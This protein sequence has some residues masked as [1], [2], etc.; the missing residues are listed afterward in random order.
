MAFT[1]QLGK[2][3]REP[4][5]PFRIAQV[6]GAEL[7]APNA[8]GWNA[9]PVVTDPLTTLD[10]SPITDNH[11][12]IVALVSL[13]Y[14]TT[15]IKVT[16]DW[17]RDRDEQLLFHLEYSIPDPKSSGYAYWPWLYAYSYIARASWEIAENGAYH[18]RVSVGDTTQTVTF[19]VTGMGAAPPPSGGIFDDILQWILSA[20]STI[21]ST[22][23]DWI[24][25][26]L[27]FLADGIT[28]AF[29]T[30]TGWLA[31]V[32]GALQLG[33]DQITAAVNGV[34]TM[35]ADLTGGMWLS[36]TTA[37]AHGLVSFTDTITGLFDGLYSW[38]GS[39][40]GGLETRI[41]SA[42]LTTA[43]SLL[44]PLLALPGQVSAELTSW[45]DA[46]VN[47]V[48]SLAYYIGMSATNIM[49]AI[50]TSGQSLLSSLTTTINTALSTWWDSFLGKLFDFGSWAGGLLDAI[51]AWLTVDVPGH[52][53]RWTA[54]LDDFVRIFWGAITGP[55]LLYCATITPVLITGAMAALQ[56]VSSALVDLLEQSM[57]AITT[58][59][60]TIGPVTP[61]SA[62]SVHASLV[63]VMTTVVA[64]L[65][66]MTIAG[67][68]T[69]MGSKIGLGNVSAMIYDLT[70]YKALTG[71][72]VGALA[73]AAVAIP[74]RYYYNSL[75]RPNLPGVGQCA[76]ME[77]EGD[78]KP[79]EYTKLMGFH[80]FPDEWHENMKD[81]SYRAPTP[82]T[83]KIMAKDGTF[84]DAM[85]TKALQRGHY[86]PEFIP[87]MIDSIRKAS[88]G[89][90]Q[91]IMISAAVNRFKLGLTDQPTFE[92]EL[93]VLQCAENLLP[94]YVYGAN[95]DYTTSFTLELMTA[96]VDG[97]RAGNI[98]IED[99]R[100]LLLGLG[101]MP[102]RVEADVYREVVRVKPRATTTAVTPGAATYTT[103]AGKLAVDTIRRQRRKGVLDRTM[104]I[105]ALLKLGMDGAYAAAVADNDDIRLGESPATA[106]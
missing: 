66:A 31:G 68:M 30:L 104:Q 49:S 88:V 12:A 92:N 15:A 19:E 70:N 74:L 20:T 89:T 82:Y 38:L 63:K 46:V 95:L 58:A 102:E 40:L 50:S 23:N 34:Y 28:A 11:E 6:F 45:A 26:S 3:L 84:D 13:T 93:R 103:D 32:F 48:S 98:S 54:I 56:P 8:N 80:G 36:I 57:A 96:Y 2:G 35:L 97:V 51:G 17:Y 21:T 16:L 81:L 14:I 99:Y 71:A 24:T 1:V 39:E 59:T 73:A 69:V 106:A 62:L 60:A 86:R 79:G 22:V 72:F 83:M 85:M 61:G 47:A 37:V 9:V 100:D 4:V 42:V 101:L 43:A 41:V 53:P 29:G 65:A 52:S 91:A 18:V 94:L 7:N 33:L 64:G 105:V 44:G 76:E 77:I 67:E 87:M 10:V 27:A 55:Y 5:S 75:F 78:L 25:D 90:P